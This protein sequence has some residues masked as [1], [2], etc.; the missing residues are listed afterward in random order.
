M[1]GLVLCGLLL[2]VC[3][4]PVVVGATAL[5]SAGSDEQQI[6][7]LIAQYAHAV[8]EASPALVD[9][10]WS[11][12]GEVSFIYPLGEEH[13]LTAIEEHVFRDVMGGMFS[14]RDLQIEE[15]EIYVY[16]DTAWSEFHWVFHATQRKDGSAV[17]SKG[18]ETQIYRREKDGWRL[19]HVHYSGV[20]VAG[21]SPP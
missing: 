10:V 3:A 7:Q 1:K 6:R 4:W 18:V 15:P 9:Q 5:G 21:S 13:G 14:K 12:A 8:D 20:T 17:V 11:H 16:G 2:A 19:V